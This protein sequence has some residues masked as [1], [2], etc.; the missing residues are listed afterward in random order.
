MSLETHPTVRRYFERVPPGET[1]AIAEAMVDDTWL[2]R[3]ALDCGADDVGLVEITRPARGAAR[4]DSAELS[5]DEVA[6]E[7]RFAHGA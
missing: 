3:I 7:H 6:A 5:L 4:G 1:A 2:R